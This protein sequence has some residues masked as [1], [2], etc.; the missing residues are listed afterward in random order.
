MNLYIKHT[1]PEPKKLATAGLKAF[2]NLSEEWKLTA[3]QERILL[4]SPPES[5]FF[6]WKKEKS[7]SRLSRDVM[8]RIS[9]LL[10]I[11]KALKILLPDN[12]AVNAWIH[13]PNYAPLLNGQTALS[14]ILSGS[15]ADLVDLRRY[16]DAERG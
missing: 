6:K 12:E 16:L 15:M 1:A 13:K 7:A 9:Y 5:T 4:G 3:S 11:Y 10:G 2:F 14:R 8:D